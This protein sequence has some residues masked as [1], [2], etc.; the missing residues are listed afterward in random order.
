MVEA[1]V[2]VVIITILLTILLPTLQNA[3]HSTK[4]ATCAS[5][6]K[7]YGAGMNRAIRHD[8]MEFSAR[9]LAT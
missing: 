1:L 8:I 3:R 6:L 9:V 2:V 5:N 7:Q 4:V